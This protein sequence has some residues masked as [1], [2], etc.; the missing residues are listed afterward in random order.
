M[1]DY[2]NALYAPAPWWLLLTLIIVTVELAM[3]ALLFV[4]DRRRLR[5]LRAFEGQRRQRGSR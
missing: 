1:I 4:V 5:A 3:L 2:L